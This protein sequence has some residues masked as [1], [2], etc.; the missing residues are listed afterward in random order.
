MSLYLMIFLNFSGV[1]A[2]S[3]CYGEPDKHLKV[4]FV[5]HIAISILP[6]EKLKML[7]ETPYVIMFNV[8]TILILLII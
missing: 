3:F 7:I 2:N 1:N 4:T 5:E 8:M 6:L